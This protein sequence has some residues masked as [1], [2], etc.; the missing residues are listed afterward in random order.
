MKFLFG[1]LLF[2]ILTV[3]QPY[4]L[5]CIYEWHLMELFGLPRISWVQAYMIGTIFSLF[6]YQYI[7][8]VKQKN[9]SDILMATSIKYGLM[10]VVAY[11]L[12][13]V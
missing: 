7:L 11:L 9:I 2:I 1:F 12:K 13:G 5:I 8:D 10:L 4:V 6:N 3:L